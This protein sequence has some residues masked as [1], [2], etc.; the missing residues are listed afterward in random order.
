VVY[1]FALGYHFRVLHREH[2]L[3]ALVPIYLGWTAAFVG[4][5]RAARAAAT[6]TWLEAG[7]RAFERERAYLLERWG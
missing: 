4:G 5:T 1:D 2:L 6:E 3:R 7:A